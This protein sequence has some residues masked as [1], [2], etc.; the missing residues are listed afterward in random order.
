[1]LTVQDLSR[2]TKELILNLPPS[3]QSQEA[4]VARR[5]IAGDLEQMRAEGIMPDLPSDFD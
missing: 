1:M 2:I 5:E 3:N 4:A